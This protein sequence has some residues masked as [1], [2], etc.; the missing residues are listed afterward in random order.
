MKTAIFNTLAK[1]PLVLSAALIAPFFISAPASADTSGLV[2][3]QA[4]AQLSTSLK[5]T[6]QAYEALAQGD[7]TMARTTLDKALR[8]MQSAVAKEPTLGV[9]QTSATALHS[10]LKSI[11][12]KMRTADKSAV[13]SELS[14]VLARAGITTGA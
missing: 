10:E 1:K 7:V 13:K 6:V 2:N 14:S 3:P 5:D 12:S 4:V 8:T 9:A 11:H